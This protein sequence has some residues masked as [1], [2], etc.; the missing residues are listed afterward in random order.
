MNANYQLS[1]PF[2]ISVFLPNESSDRVVD[3]SLAYTIAESQIPI[4]NSR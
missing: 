4:N 2:S 1:K 3:L